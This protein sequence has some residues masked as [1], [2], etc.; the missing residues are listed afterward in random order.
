MKQAASIEAA[1][2]FFA[3]GSGLCL[4]ADDELANFV[5]L[6]RKSMTQWALVAQLI[7]ECFCFVQRL[8]SHVRACEQFAKI[9]LDFGFGKQSINPSNEKTRMTT[10]FIF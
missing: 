6:F 9:F 2:F 4:L 7:N 3:F 10:P 5:Q 1:C 8:C